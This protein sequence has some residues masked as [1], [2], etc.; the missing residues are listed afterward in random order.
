MPLVVSWR[1]DSLDLTLWPTTRHVIWLRKPVH[2]PALELN[3]TAIRYNTPPY[4]CLS[5]ASR[6]A[7]RGISPPFQVCPESTPQYTPVETRASMS[8]FRHKDC[9]KGRFRL[10]CSWDAVWSPSY[11]A[12]KLHLKSKPPFR[13]PAGC[14]HLSAGHLTSHNSN[15]PTWSE[16]QFFPTQ[17]QDS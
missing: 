4:Y 14:I 13:R 2:F 12:W 1:C 3:R 7:G 15:H 11:S 6:R 17:S 10:F 9:T 5:P 16:T 8:S